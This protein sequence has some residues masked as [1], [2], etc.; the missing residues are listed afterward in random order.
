[1]S[2]TQDALLLAAYLGDASA[3]AATKGVLP[4]P[5]EPPAELQPW[6]A[7]IGGWGPG[8]ALRAVLAVARRGAPAGGPGDQQNLVLAA[9]QALCPCPE[10]Q[11]LAAKG[12][13]AGPRPGA[14][15]PRF[16]PAA[17]AAAGLA[18]DPSPTPDAR[19]SATLSRG[20]SGLAGAQI[21]SA[22]KADLL[23]WALGQSDE[24][25]TTTAL[26]L[27][28]PGPIGQAARGLLRA[29]RGDARRAATDLRAAVEAAATRVEMFGKVELRL[30]P[31]AQPF[32][33]WLA[34]AEA[35]AP[36]PAQAPPEGWAS[37]ARA[38]PPTGSFVRP[39]RPRLGDHGRPRLR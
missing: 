11:A 22:V 19:W 27:A 30:P 29:R 6:L 25:L 34:A 1:M 10:H 2:P 3:R 12:R 9:C 28:P 20:A 23:A 37:P 36:L 4:G 8:A 35:G 31:Y 32:A 17:E 39:D 5:P 21:R 26:E 13:Y 33:T 18:A 38:R 16:V 14:S 7:A 24:P 15:D